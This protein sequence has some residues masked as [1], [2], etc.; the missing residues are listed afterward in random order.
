[1]F[2][3]LA[4]HIELITLQGGIKLYSIFFMCLDENMLDIS[5]LDCS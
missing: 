3:V 2:S 1:M 5:I 4:L